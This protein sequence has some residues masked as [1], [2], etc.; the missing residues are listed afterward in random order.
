MSK[1][2]IANAEH[3]RWGQACDGWHLLKSAGLSIIQERVPPECGE[4]RHFHH[5]AEQFF[6]IL[7]GV[8]S[9]DIAGETLEVHPQQ[10]VHIAAGEPHA[11]QN[12]GEQDIEFLVISSPPSHGDKTLL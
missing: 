1:K 9:I 7:S 10:G 5:H 12:K 3:Y 4:Q 11:L 2:S 6:Y 8:A